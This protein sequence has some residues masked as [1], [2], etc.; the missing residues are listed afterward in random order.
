MPSFVAH[1][2]YSDILMEE[3]VKKIALRPFKRAVIQVKC[4]NVF[5]RK[6]KLVTLISK[7]L[8]FGTFHKLYTYLILNIMI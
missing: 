2:A 1:K 3:F 8:R 4:L 6:W 7:A 5:Y